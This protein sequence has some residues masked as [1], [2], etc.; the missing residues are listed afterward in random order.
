MPSPIFLGASA[1]LAHQ[2]WMSMI[3]NNIAN[4][5]TFGFK[6]SR[7]RFG[8]II[9]SAIGNQTALGSGVQRTGVDA[10]FAT[11]A[12]QPTGQPLDIAL[13]GKGFFVL[14]DGNKDVYTR[15]GSFLVNESKFLADRTTGFRVQ[16]QQGND[17][18]I[19]PAAFRVDG[20]ATTS[21]DLVGNLDPNTANGK[22]FKTS[23]QV[24]DSK[25]DTHT[26]TLTYTRDT[27]ANNW[28][29]VISTP[30]S[31]VTFPQ[32]AGPA[33]TSD[34]TITNV[35]Y[36][37]TGAFSTFTDTAP[38]APGQADIQVNFGSGNQT[39]KFTF[40]DTTQSSGASNLKQSNKDGKLAVTFSNV[41]ITEE[42]EVK[43]VLSDGNAQTVTTLGIGLF[44]NQAGLIPKGN[45]ILEAS[46]TTG[47]VKLVRG[48][49][50]GSGS[51]RAG[52][53]ESSNVDMTTELV[54]LI[55]AQRGYSMG[56]RIVQ[57]ADQVLQEA[58]NL[59]R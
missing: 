54:N 10:D 27:A 11:G 13:A 56:A 50:N 55:V 22:T 48:G 39:V 17:I 3:G 14:N 52:F 59:K 2:D 34:N 35:T 33:F 37:G 1:I 12:L 7:M 4:I 38:N 8:D 29:L 46:N 40:T 44:D 26:L 28:D 24:F 16:D 30:E 20:T 49:T 43:A 6:T 18:K 21:V 53:L 42:G 5:N 15:V 47:S 45:G 19:D 9:G 25:G 41:A 36:T 51:I 31:N 58:I 32:G 57:T 23:A